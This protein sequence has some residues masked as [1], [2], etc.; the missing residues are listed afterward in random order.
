MEVVSAINPELV[1]RY[2][3]LVRKAQKY[4]QEGYLDPNYKEYSEM[5]DPA[6]QTSLNEKNLLIMEAQWNDFDAGYETW[7]KGKDWRDTRDKEERAAQTALMKRQRSLANVMTGNS[8]TP[9]R[10][11]VGTLLGVGRGSTLLGR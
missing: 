10:S 11:S 5:L 3:E 2:N 7:R 9:A 6:Q 8:A 4:R 1:K